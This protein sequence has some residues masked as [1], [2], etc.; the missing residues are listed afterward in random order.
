MASPAKAPIAVKAPV[1]EPV[2]E[3]AKPLI[4]GRAVA[5]NRAG[6]P[7]QRSAAETGVDD[8]AIPA[9][10]PPPGW[11]WEWKRETVKG[12]TDP[13]YISRLMQVGWE[14]VMYES[15]PGVFAP[16]FDHD[17]KPTKGP[18]RRKG[19]ALYERALVLTKEAMADEKRKADEKVGRAKHQ[20]SKIDTGGAP[21]AAFDHEAQRASY[22]RSQNERVD[23][24]A[25]AVLQ[26]PID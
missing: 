9:H 8:F 20:Y 6:Q 24:P 10:L 19:L 7:I 26:P 1:H 15:Y 3:P 11:S 13:Q 21:T 25:N 2:K 23:M 18:V 17:G 16:E 12:E 14:P 4:A 5:Y 22:I